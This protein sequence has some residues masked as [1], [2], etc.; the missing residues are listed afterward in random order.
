MM[1]CSWLKAELATPRQGSDSG[2]SVSLVPARLVSESDYIGRHRKVKGAVG[3]ECL[4]VARLSIDLMEGEQALDVLVTPEDSTPLVLPH[5][6]SSLSKL[7]KDGPPAL[8]MGSSMAPNV[9]PEIS[10]PG[11]RLGAGQ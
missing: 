8:L 3:Q 1:T 5:F 10:V 4:P 7:L 6:L 2:A 11:D 9:V